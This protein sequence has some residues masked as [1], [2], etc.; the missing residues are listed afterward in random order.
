[1]V[2]VKRNKL[3]VSI[4][5][6]QGMH[7][8]FNVSTLI[9][10]KYEKQKKK[11]K[12]KKIELAFEIGLPVNKTQFSKTVT[13][14]DTFFHKLVMLVNIMKTGTDRTGAFYKIII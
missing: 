14:N 6:K 1:M 13:K 12:Y 2:S 8:I 4:N 7:V 9:K 5:F 10:D 3:L 11:K